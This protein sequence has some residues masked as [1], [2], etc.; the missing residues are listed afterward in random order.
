VNY[1]YECFDAS[2]E[3]FISTAADDP[4][5]G[6]TK[7]M[8]GGYRDVIFVIVVIKDSRISR[9]TPYLKDALWH[10]RH[11]PRLKRNWPGAPG[12]WV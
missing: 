5:T 4:Q 7:M 11:P 12:K 8:D 3:H 6:A 10:L 1:P 2:V 9:Y